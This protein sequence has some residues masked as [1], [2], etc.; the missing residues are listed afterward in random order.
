VAQ[1]HETL[2]PDAV[3]L[4]D[5]K[6]RLLLAW[7]PPAQQPDRRPPGSTWNTT[8]AT[9]MAELLHAT[10]VPLGLVTNGERFTLVYAEPEQPTGFADFRA[11]LWFDERLTLRA[12]RDFLSADALFNRPPEQT[13]DAL[14]RRSLENQ[15][16]VSTTLGR[17]VRRAV[18]MFVAALDRADREGSRTLLQGLSEEH[19]YEAALTLMMRLVF[20]FFAEERDLL[21]IVNPVY[22]ENYAVTTLHDQLREAANRLGE[23]VLE[24]R[25]DAFPRL[26]AAFRAVHGGIEHDL[27]AL[28]AYGGDLFDPDRFPFLEGRVAGSTWQATPAQ[29]FPIHN[30][31]VLHLLEALQFLEMKVPGGGRETRRLSFRA[32]DIEQIGHVYEGLLDHTARRA[33][34]I[35]LGLDGKEEPEIALSEI[36]RRRG[37]PDFVEWLAGETGRSTRTIEKA[38]EQTTVDDPLRWPEWEQVAPYAGLVRRDDNGDPWV[39]PAG[40]LYV[41]T[42]AARRQTGTQYTP[43]SLTE[44]VVEHALAPLVYT[45]PAEGKPPEDWQMKP[46]G[47]ILDLKVCDFACGS[48]AFLVAAARYLSARLV[49]A[50]EAAQREHGANVQ[51]TPYGHPSSGLP[52]EELIPANPDERGLYALRIVVERCL[53]GVDRN[54]LAVEMAKL[55]LWLLTLQR[56][57]PF[58][59]LD[60]AIRCGDSL[61][62]VDLKQLSTWSLSGEGKQSVLFDDDLSFA[63]DKREGLMKMQY[64]P[65][66]QRR[67]L[68]AALAKTRR[69][70]AAADR[71]IATA[72][73]A[74]PE[75]SAA[76]VAMGLEEQEAEARK[77]LEGKRPFHW[78]VEFPEV[79]LHG[80]GFDAIVGNPPFIGGQRITG[81]L[82]QPYRDYLVE[83]IA[84]GQRGSA[85]YVA[86]FFLRAQRLLKG[87][88]SA[89]LL[90]TNT[91]AQGDT[92]EVGLDQ[93]AARGTSIYR[94]IPSRKWPGEANLEVAHVW[95]R[96]GKWDGP[97]V[98]DDVLVGGITSQLQPPGRVIG[99]PF[100]LA[101][102]SGKSFQGSIVLGMGFVL[103]PEAAQRLLDKDP[104]NRD[105]LFQY[106]NGEDLNGRWDQSPSRWVINFR[107]WP[108]EKA[109]EYLDC[110]EIVARLVKPEREANKYSKTARERWWLYERWRPE[111]YDTIAG[112]ERVLVGCQTAKYVSLAFEPPIYLYSHATNVFAT[113]QEA[114]FALLA[115]S[116]HDVWAREHSGSLETRLRYSPTDCFETFP[117]PPALDSLESIGACYYAHRSGIMST[118][119]DGLTVTYNRFHSPHEVSHDIATLRALHVEMD[120]AVAAAYGWTDLDLGHGLRETKQGIRHTISEAARREVLDR[121]LALN[122]ERYSQEQAAVPEQPRPKRKTR[123]R[124][125]AQPGLF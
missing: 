54:P 26:L 28:P 7:V 10:R 119:R 63:A 120:H 16:E 50:W 107:D 118:R 58:T 14:Y 17:Q 95:F 104:H 121:L 11:E 42:G 73:E 75:A 101:A 88:G 125:P 62:G 66:D 71:L 35:V 68:D 93:I 77:I 56:N 34:E 110:F 69:L 2:R 5:G 9:R 47:Q 27:A 33:T 24:R 44:S 124:A 82:G 106:L 115:G 117:F 67:L 72:F 84:G 105:V 8:H 18:E 61:L 116:I 113:E 38:L 76:A 112:L 70:R 111:L 51:I 98:L 30:R 19:I 123:G 97:F 12:F 4:E 103:E 99:K 49:E 52:E 108:M 29:P 91:I 92:R 102:N 48:A 15:Q 36:N 89:G 59:F 41:T 65:G 46:A 57:R 39:I 90:A 43:R 25:Y 55:S 122:H 60:H 1:H 6:P 23:E 64:H 79:F 109:M 21:P 31:T 114:V 3:L 32:L 45:G 74:N 53:Y 40:S 94:A 81:A 20:L 96:K 13:L 100:R 86:Y 22:R 80:S 85:D 37:Q 87:D 83:Y 78:P